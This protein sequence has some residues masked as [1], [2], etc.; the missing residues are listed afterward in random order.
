[1]MVGIESG[2]DRHVFLTPHARIEF[3]WRE[4][5]WVHTMEGVGDCPEL[6]PVATVE[7]DPDRDDP[8]RVISPAYQQA[9]VEIGPDGIVR[10]LLVG[11]SG[12]HHFS[13]AFAVTADE[14]GTLFDADVA[15][16]CRSPIAALAATYQLD[17]ASTE[18]D[19][20]GSAEVILRAGGARLILQA[21]PSARAIVEASGPGPRIHAQILAGI[22]PASQTYRFRYRWRWSVG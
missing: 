6:P 14:S 18:I 8:A 12:P 19:G 3:A 4:D 16:R 2:D 5:R 9:H 15:D 1:M 11:Q 17:P 20:D 21:V 22:E 7:V 10:M 13:A